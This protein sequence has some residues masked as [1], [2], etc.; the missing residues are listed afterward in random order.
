MAAAWRRPWPTR[1]PSCKTWGTEY[2]P[3]WAAAASSRLF[4]CAYMVCFFQDALAL[5]FLCAFFF[6]GGGDAFPLSSRCSRAKSYI[7]AMSSRLCCKTWATEYGPAWVS[8]GGEGSGR[9]AGRASLTSR[10]KSHFFCVPCLRP[11]FI[12]VIIIL[13]CLRLLSGTHAVR[14]AKNMSTNGGVDV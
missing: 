3:A 14:T 1:G 11:P 10:T 12:F 8:T 9:C 2:G 4:F 7:I 5:F 6:G 13:C